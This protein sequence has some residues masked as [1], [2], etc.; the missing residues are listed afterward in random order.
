MEA[1]KCVGRV[2]F[3]KLTWALQGPAQRPSARHEAVIHRHQ[4][5]CPDFSHTRGDEAVNFEKLKHFQRMILK[6]PKFPV[7][8]GEDSQDRPSQTA[9]L[10]PTMGAVGLH[11][12]AEV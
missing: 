5:T 8:M 12:C 4:E 1:L 6:C 9:S 10:W 7:W 3:R 2:H 11:L